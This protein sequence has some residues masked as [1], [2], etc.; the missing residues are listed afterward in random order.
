MTD[1][2]QGPFSSALSCPGMVLGNKAWTLEW[3]G[4][5][6]FGRNCSHDGLG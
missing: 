3:I 5:N 2:F 6:Q 4:L 1:S